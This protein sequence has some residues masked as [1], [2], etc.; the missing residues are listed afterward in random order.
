MEEENQVTPE[1][2]AAPAEETAT[3]PQVFNYVVADQAAEPEAPSSNP[4]SPLA[5]G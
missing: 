3:A 1:E 5:A 2:T 4:Y